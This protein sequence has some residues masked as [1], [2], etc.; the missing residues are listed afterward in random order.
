MCFGEDVRGADVEQHP[1]ERSERDE[2]P[3]VWHGE[4]QGQGSPGHRCDSVD[5]EQG[6]GASA[7][8]AVAQHEADGVEAIGEVVRED[9]ERHRNTNRRTGLKAMPIAM[10]SIR[11]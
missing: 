11:L 2:Q 1:C 4:E 3:A 7:G 9:R 10:P 5:P 6:E 8:V